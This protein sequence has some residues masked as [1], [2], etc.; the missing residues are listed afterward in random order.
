MKN[1]SIIFWVILSIITSFLVT[2]YFWLAETKV[3]SF[4]AEWVSAFGTVGAVA[5]ALYIQFRNESIVKVQNNLNKQNAVCLTLLNDLSDI[6]K[7]LNE[8]FMQL[9]NAFVKSNESD[10]NTITTDEVLALKSKA[11]NIL[12]EKWQL[13]SR[14]VEILNEGEQYE[15]R[16]ALQNMSDVVLAKI[17]SSETISDLMSI[18]NGD[19]YQYIDKIHNI[20]ST[21]Y[22]RINS[23]V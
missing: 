3:P 12:S 21:K 13:N 15:C 6:R 22:Q 18:M 7:E 8:V 20:I 4:V 10:D 14:L 9:A 2:T 16:L 1:K 17:Y 19:P 5:T 11:S 23:L